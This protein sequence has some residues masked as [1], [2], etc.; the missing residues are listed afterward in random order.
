[1]WAPRRGEESV[2]TAPAR[3]RVQAWWLDAWPAS[4]FA[5]VRRDPSVAL[6]RDFTPR[7]LTV[8]GTEVRLESSEFDE[9][10]F[11]TVRLSYPKGRPVV[12]RLGGLFTAESEPLPLAE[13]HRWF[14]GVGK[15]TARFGPLGARERREPFTLDVYLLEDVKARSTQV[16]LNMVEPP[17]RYKDSLL[18]KP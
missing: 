1:S 3:P 15:Y 14:F 17:D 18:W 12:A 4:D 7:A 5:S 8:G 10:G 11:L 13:E 9:K 16:D 2:L 6:E